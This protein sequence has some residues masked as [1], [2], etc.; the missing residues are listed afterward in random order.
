MRGH[1]QTQVAL[2]DGL[3]VSVYPRPAEFTAGDSPG[4]MA[5]VPPCQRRST[6]S[7]AIEDVHPRHDSV[8]NSHFN[9]LG[10]KTTL[11][12][13]LITGCASAPPSTKNKRKTGTPSP[14]Q[15]CS[16]PC[17]DRL[18]H[19]T[20]KA[21]SSLEPSSHTPATMTSQAAEK[22]QSTGLDNCSRSLVHTPVMTSIA[23]RSEL[24]VVTDSQLGGWTT[25]FGDDLARGVCPACG[26][27]TVAELRQEAVEMAAGTQ[28]RP[29]FTRLFE[30]NCG[31]NHRD[32]QVDQ[33]KCGRY[34]LVRVM[35]SGSTPPLVPADDSS[36]L[37]P[38]SALQA[39]ATSEQSQ[40]KAA[41][42]KWI[43]GITAL[44]SV[45]GISGLVVGKDAVSGL[46]PSG[47]V[48]IGIALGAGCI[49]AACAIFASYRAA[50]GWPKV[51]NLRDD[52]KLREWFD[53]RQ[54]YTRTAAT[55]LRYAVLC[56]GISLAAL[57]AAVGFVWFWP[58]SPAVPLVTI[59]LVDGST[60]C[61]EL[62]SSLNDGHIKIQLSS[63]SIRNPPIAKI[64][65]I[66]NSV[67]CATS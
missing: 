65:K 13:G 48:A 36:L 63:Q 45:F 55:S 10:V 33:R 19:R 49:A 41:A 38:A 34:W 46:E 59:T 5:K 12:G 44:F 30:C 51:V 56:A 39:S 52:V 43:A 66:V 27:V 3:L 40:V 6:L 23:Y 32:G 67:S 28:S 24:V 4:G 31:Q 20:R 25:D 8:L 58:S 17:D 16:C 2:R 64:V 9:E 26:D 42:E 47:K 14:H 21:S 1:A 50:Y 22:D 37:A 57:L 53:K 60:I 11:A 54:G 7:A 18:R 15:A 29:G 61:G 35:P 62:V